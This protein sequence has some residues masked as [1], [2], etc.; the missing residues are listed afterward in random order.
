L[1]SST[2]DA[3]RLGW[4]L[5]ITAAFMVLEVVG[6]VLSGSLAL[7][8]DGGHM[9]TDTA[10]LALAWL[11][12]R[13]SLRPGTARHGHRAQLWAAFTNALALLFVVAWILWEAAQR[14]TEPRGIAAGPMLGIAVA[15][16]IANLVVLRV[17]GRGHDANLNVA[18]ARLHVLGDLL[19]SVAACTAA[20]VIL[21]SGWTPID[22]L[23]SVLVALLI[24]RSAAMLLAQST[25]ALLTHSPSPGELAA[26][27]SGPSASRIAERAPIGRDERR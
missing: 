23:L 18:A 3:R 1:S 14:L 19:G 4:A 13:F 12:A 16:L 8:A 11:A 25:R 21:T 6:G 22:P 27:T 24:L 9:L 5:L 10:S 26:R 17:L 2:T 7:L 15:G 20:I